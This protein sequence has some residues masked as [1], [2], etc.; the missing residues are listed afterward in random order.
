MNAFIAGL[1]VFATWIL[2]FLLLPIRILICT[3]ELVRDTIQYPVM[4][5]RLQDEND[6]EVEE[7]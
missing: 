2:M 3:L 6:N 4:L 5:H 7:A 1:Y